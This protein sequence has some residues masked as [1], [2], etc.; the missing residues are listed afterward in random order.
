M[1][2][3]EIKNRIIETAS[4]LFYKNGY[5]ATGIN[6]IISEAGIAKATLYNHFKSKEDICI[7]YLQFKDTTFIE[8][9]KE[10]TASK[11]KGKLQVL[12]IF[13][14]LELFFKSNEFNGCWCIKTISEIP[15]DNKKIRK[16]IQLQKKV[17]IQFI[18]KL[19]ATNI[20]TIKEEELD[21]KSRKIYL[22]Y[23]SAVG[24][25]H[26]HQAN[27]PI[28]EAKNLCSYLLE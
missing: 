4:S 8:S 25:S 13:D 1:K 5:N 10:Y 26:L 18:S 17:F 21:S 11:P 28:K 15:L 3:S 22:L 12:A 24:E 9:I 19:I 23:E 6:E 2:H 7:A 14:F 20:T 27:W 16:E